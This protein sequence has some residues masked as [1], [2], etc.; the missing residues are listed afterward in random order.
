MQFYV[1][2]RLGIAYNWSDYFVGL[3]MQF[4]RFSYKMDDT[5]VVLI[6][7]YARAYS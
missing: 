5:K 7:G 3:Q 2:A 1:D 6:D 4:N